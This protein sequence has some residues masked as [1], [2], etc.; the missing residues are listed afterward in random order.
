MYVSQTQAMSDDSH[1]FVVVTMHYYYS[2]ETLTELVRNTNEEIGSK[3]CLEK[4]A[5][6]HQPLYNKITF[7][8]NTKKCQLFV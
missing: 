7:L 5:T 8:G 1:L 6:T 3:L 2:F 4:T